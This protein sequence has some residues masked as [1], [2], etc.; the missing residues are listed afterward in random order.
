[1]GPVLR[2]L[3]SDSFKERKGRLSLVQTGLKVLAFS[4]VVDIKVEKSSM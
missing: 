4:I 1:M 3:F 2:F